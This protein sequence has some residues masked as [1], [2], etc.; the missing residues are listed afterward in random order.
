[1]MGLSGRNS[2]EI[3]LDSGVYSMWSRDSPNPVE[4]KTLPSPTI[5][6]THPLFFSRSP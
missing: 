2:D 1:M 6:N 5:Y 3:Y 4:T